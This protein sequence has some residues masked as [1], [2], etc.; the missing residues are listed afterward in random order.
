M[1]ALSGVTRTTLLLL[2]DGLENGRLVDAWFSPHSPGGCRRVR[3][4]RRGCS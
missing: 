3:S 1:A 4:L 2:A